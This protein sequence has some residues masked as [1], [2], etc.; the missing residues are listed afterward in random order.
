[1]GVVAGNM[2]ESRVQGGASVAKQTTTNI[3][4][5]IDA[6]RRLG[7]FKR[8]MNELPEGTNEIDETRTL[9]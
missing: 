8:K 5:K 9:W 3:V 4:D 1:M 2:K 7:S 6:R